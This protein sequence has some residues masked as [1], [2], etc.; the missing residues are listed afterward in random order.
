MGKV[1]YI[2]F[3]LITTIGEIAQI[4]IY[5]SL[6][7]FFGSN[8]QTLNKILS[9]SLLGVIIILII[10]YLIYERRR[11]RRIMLNSK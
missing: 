2:K 3:F 6:G 11:R 4:G 5:A 1:K 10:I 7:Y 9:K 8:W